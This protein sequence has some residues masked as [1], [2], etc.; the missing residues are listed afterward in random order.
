MNIPLHYTLCALDKIASLHNNDSG[1]TN[2]QTASQF[3]MLII[4][5]AFST[6]FR[7][8]NFHLRN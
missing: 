6:S 7:K 4:F 1:R 3:E 8:D 2:Y 5:L